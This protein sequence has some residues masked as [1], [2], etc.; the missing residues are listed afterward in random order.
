M[1]LYN[2]E[3]IS[4]TLKLKPS[5]SFSSKIESWLLDLEKDVHEK[6]S[7]TSIQIL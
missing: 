2:E 4:S 1:N 3:D 7:P 6:L 5:Y